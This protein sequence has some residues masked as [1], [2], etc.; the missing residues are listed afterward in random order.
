MCQKQMDFPPESVLDIIAKNPV[1]EKC[2]RLLF[3][4]MMF[5]KGK[6]NSNT[7]PP[8]CLYVTEHLVGQ[9]KS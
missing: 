9:E 1:L 4:E 3:W 7:F 6:V 8:H 2:P 5:D